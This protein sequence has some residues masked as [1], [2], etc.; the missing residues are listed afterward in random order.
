MEAEEGLPLDSI[1]CEVVRLVEQFEPKKESPTKTKKK[2]G[3]NK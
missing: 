1:T 2:T 3:N